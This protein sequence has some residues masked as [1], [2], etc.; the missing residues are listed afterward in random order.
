MWCCG[1]FVPRGQKKGNVKRGKGDWDVLLF[2]NVR[3][4]RRGNCEVHILEN[5][6][7]YF[8]LYVSRLPYR[9][10]INLLTGL[11]FDS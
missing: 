10:G 8:F 2:M 6:Y 7:L 5:I 9:R 4:V 1:A 11:F 3:P